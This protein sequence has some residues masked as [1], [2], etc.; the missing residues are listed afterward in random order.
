MGRRAD[1]VGFQASVEEALRTIGGAKRQKICRCASS[2][3]D[4]GGGQAQVSLE[5]AE[6]G[7]SRQY[8]PTKRDSPPGPRHAP[9]YIPKVIRNGTSFPWGA[10]VPAACGTSTAR[11]GLSLSAI[12]VGFPR[13]AD[14][15]DKGTTLHFPGKLSTYPQRCADLLSQAC[16]SGN[17]V[18]TTIDAIRT[19]GERQW[20]RPGAPIDR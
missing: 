13:G 8:G 16:A 12:S 9:T 2:G 18:L 20:V 10:S 1:F 17:P 11:L 6:K 14:L 7:G 5:E 15:V 3:G 19:A 4:W